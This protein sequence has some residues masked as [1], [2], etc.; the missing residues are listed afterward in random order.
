MSLGAALASLGDL[1]GGAAEVRRALEPGTDPGKI[2][3]LLGP[4]LVDAGAAEASLACFKKLLEF[5]PDNP[6]AQHLVAARTGASVERD[7]SGYVR[8]LFDRYADTFDQHL[9]SLSYTPRELMVEILAAG[10]RATPWDCLDLGC[11]TGLFGIEIAS[12]S[13]RLVGVDVSARMIERARELDL[14]TDLRRTDLLT[15]LESE[16]ADSYDVVAAADVFPYVG[17][18]DSI[19]PL[20]RHVLRR[21][22][23]FGFSTEAAESS[24]TTDESSSRG[25]LAGIRGRYAHTLKYL[26]ALA[27]RH[28]FRVTHVKQTVIRTDNARPVMGWLVVWLA[29]AAESSRASK[30]GCA[31]DQ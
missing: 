26:D 20:V 30:A 9:K 14:Y 22:G 13:R 23:V 10:D 4:I 27:R 28:D 31:H 18:L 12:R 8:R 29:G 1:E 7:P 2:Y 11:G 6:L 16:A 21:D 24:P 17:G 19:V 3:A 25:Y 5:E 15:A